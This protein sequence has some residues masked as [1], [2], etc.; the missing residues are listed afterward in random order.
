MSRNN[1]SIK[2][3]R[4]LHSC[5]WL[6]PRRIWKSK[7]WKRNVLL[8]VT[9]CSWVKIKW[10]AK[11][12]WSELQVILFDF[13]ILCLEMFSKSSLVTY[14][15]EEIIGASANV[16]AK[17]RSDTFV[18]R[19]HQ[20][21]S[22][23]HFPCP[24]LAYPLTLLGWFKGRMT[25]AGSWLVTAFSCF[26]FGYVLICFIQLLTNTSGLPSYKLDH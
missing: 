13:L 9:A 24:K 10:S 20:Q 2:E 14:C 21:K 15:Q 7:P 11:G 23:Y 22:L 25:D 1:L 4:S 16:K 8:A 12:L 17:V 3:V 5:P 18:S 26:I 19:S 6:H